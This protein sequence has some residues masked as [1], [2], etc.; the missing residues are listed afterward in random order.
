[1]KNLIYGIL[2]FTLAQAIIW[3]QT[4]GQFVWPWFK[5]N[6][7]LVS[8]MGGTFISYIFIK[9]TWLVAEH[10]NGELWPGRFLG[11]ASGILIFS[12]MTWYFLNEGINTK[13]MI[14][15]ALATMLFGIQIFWK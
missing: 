7:M 13:T 14:S 5:K 8:L 6:P 2:L 3:I 1:M 10:F 15:L 4:N 12:L 9:G 11:Q